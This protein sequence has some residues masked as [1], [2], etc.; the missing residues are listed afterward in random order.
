MNNNEV[1]S[2]KIDKLTRKLDKKQKMIEEMR[3]KRKQHQ[4]DDHRF[5][6]K[7][8]KIEDQIQKIQLKIKNL[9]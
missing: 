6:S 3:N 4:I 5:L 7:K 2:R 9:T 1:Y 8:K